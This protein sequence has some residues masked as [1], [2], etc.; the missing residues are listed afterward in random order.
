MILSAFESVVREHLDYSDNETTKMLAEA[1]T[2]NQ[3]QIM[4]ALTSKLYEM[5]VDKAAQ[6]DFSTI[7]ASRG[8]ITKVENYDKIVETIDIM[9]KLIIEYKCDPAPIKTVEDAIENV[10]VRT[11]AFKKAFLIGSPVPVLL[12]NSVVMSI[13]SSVSFLID[14][15]IEYIKDPKTQSF[16][17]AVDVVAYNKTKDNLMLENLVSFNEACASGSNDIDAALDVCLKAKIHKE[18]VD[19]PIAQDSPFLTDDDINGE[20]VVVHDNDKLNESVLDYVGA[21]FGKGLMCLCK[22]V[23]PLI[24]HIVYIYYYTKQRMSDYFESNANLIEMNAYQVQFNSEIDEARRT[25]IYNKQMKVAEKL[26]KKAMR[27]SIDY[28]RTKKD[29]DTANL[30]DQRTYTGKDLGINPDDEDIEN[31][32]N[33]S[34]LF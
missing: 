15:C 2:A 21:V 6:I 25:Q 1:S 4:V 11:P 18:S 23:I 28:K 20:K 22:V 29:V 16:Q 34:V 33:N 13:V 17:M 27:T 8:D 24:R 14:S 9:K 3:N 12:Y 32:V 7:E 26:R 10:K 30:Q 5:I 31:Q 19:F